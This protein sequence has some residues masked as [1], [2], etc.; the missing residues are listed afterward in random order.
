MEFARQTLNNLANGRSG[1][2]PEMACRLSKAFG[3]TPEVWLR[4]QMNYGLAQVRKNEN[5]ISVD[6]YRLRDALK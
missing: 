6:R 4:L 1:I 5:E 3:S 2:S